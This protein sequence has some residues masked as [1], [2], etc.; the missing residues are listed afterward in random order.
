M[1]KIV[2]ILR[3]NFSSIAIFNISYMCYKFIYV[4]SYKYKHAEDI[5]VKINLSFSL[6][7]GLDMSLCR[8]INFLFK[9]L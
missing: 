7:F 2:K 4:V 8:I 9:L 3:E 1:P 5:F 6:E